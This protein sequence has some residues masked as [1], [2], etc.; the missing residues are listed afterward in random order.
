MKINAP[1][2]APP[3][4]SARKTPGARASGDFAPETSASASGS[5]LAGGIGAAASVNSIEALMALQGADDFQA[6]R[7]RATE[8][9]FSLLDVLDD[10]KLAI[11]DGAL[12]R[13][14][15]ERLMETVR[16]QRDA[17]RDPRLEAALDEVEIRAAV[18]LA[19]HGR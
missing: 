2:P 5:A 1:R 18:E 10:L 11:L 4:S 6:A 16:T 7:K 19:K 17:T 8:R 3:V 15:L 9:A 13:D 14:T 12:P